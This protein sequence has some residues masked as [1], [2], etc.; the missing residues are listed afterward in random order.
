MNKLQTDWFEFFGDDILQKISNI[1]YNIRCLEQVGEII[2]PCEDDRFAAFTIKPSDIKVV[3]IGQDPY[4]GEDQANGLAFSVRRGVKLPPSL[5]NMF[6]E[7]NSDTGCANNAIGDLT[8]WVD[9]GVFLLNRCLT[10]SK[11]QPGS[12]DSIGWHEVTEFIVSKLS[13]DYPDIVFLLLG[14]KAQLLEYV[15]NERSTVIKTS[16]PSPMGN[17][18]NKGFFGSRCFST[19]NTVLITNGYKPIDWSIK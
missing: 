18:C 9:Q 6:K 8:Q 2:Y 14:K 10:V 19:I 16:H 7:I 4:H 11:G 5:K 17:S 12:H 3:I 1:N 13:N 15:I